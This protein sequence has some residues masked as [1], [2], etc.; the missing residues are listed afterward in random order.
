MVF[1]RDFKSNTAR[2]L[3]R[4]HYTNEESNIIKRTSSNIQENR[5]TGAHSPVI[6][7]REPTSKILNEKFRKK[8]NNYV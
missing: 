1:Y 4:K 3:H 5:S 8:M 2:D 6:P 7:E